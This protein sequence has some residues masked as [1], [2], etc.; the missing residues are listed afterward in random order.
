M[1]FHVIIHP[2]LKMFYLLY[3]S[4]MIVQMLNFVRVEIFNMLSVSFKVFS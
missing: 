2:T 1:T 3:L 4:G